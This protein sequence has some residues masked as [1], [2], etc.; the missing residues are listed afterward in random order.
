MS[1]AEQYRMCLVGET[2]LFLTH[3]HMFK[4]ERKKAS[5]L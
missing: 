1:P 5:V 4:K 3:S 2:H